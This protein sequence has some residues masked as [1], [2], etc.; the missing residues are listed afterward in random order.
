MKPYRLTAVLLLT[1]VI[2]FCGCYTI[3]RLPQAAAE[4]DEEYVEEWRRMPLNPSIPAAHAGDFDWLFYYQLPWWQDAA[5]AYYDQSSGQSFAPE[6]FRQR[7]PQ[8]SDYSGSYSGSYAPTVTSPS[9]GKQPADSSKSSGETQP[10]DT[11]R[12]FNQN[13][14]SSSPTST[15]A[16]AGTGTDSGSDRRESKS[17]G[18]GTEKTKRR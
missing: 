14:G 5:E 4:N 15:P 18:S 6:E 8:N 11:R 17:S 10:K 9:L 7:Y 2:S 16:A 1:A 3:I 12:S 13:S